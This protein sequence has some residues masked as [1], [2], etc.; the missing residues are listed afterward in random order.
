MSFL[1][2][3]PTLGF[4]APAELVIVFW[5]HSKLLTSLGLMIYFSPY[6]HKGEADS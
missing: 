5:V 3:L 4:L 2:C 1:R 6:I